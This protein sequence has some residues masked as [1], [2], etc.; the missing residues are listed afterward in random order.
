MIKKKNVIYIIPILIWLDNLKY[1]IKKLSRNYSQTRV[2]ERKREYYR[3]QNSIQRL[4]QNIADGN[5]IDIAKY[6]QLRTELY[7]YESEKC[8]GAIL[9]SKAQWANES[10]KCTKYFL[11]LEKPRQESNT[12]K[13]LVDEGIIHSNVDS[14]MNMQYHF[15]SK[16]YSCVDIGCEKK[17]TFLSFVDRKLNENEIG[18]C[19]RN[20]DMDEIVN[21]Q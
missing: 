4:S 9:R 5:R 15:Y 12:M 19:D 11:Q 10:D 16:L 21:G 13:G 14:I 6:E 7:E 2:K 20:V 3:I 1:K 8:R 18:I 17:N